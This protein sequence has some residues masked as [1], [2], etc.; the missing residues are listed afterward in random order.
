MISID[1]LEE[2]IQEILEGRLPANT[3]VG[4]ELQENPPFDNWVSYKLKNLQ[5]VGSSAWEY[6]DSDPDSDAFK[7]QSCWIADLEIVT[8]GNK[9]ADWALSLSHQFNKE[10]FRDLFEAIGLVFLSKSDIKYAPRLVSTGWEQ[11]NLF[12]VKFNMIVE[13]IDDV[14]YIEIV[15][16][17]TTILN[18]DDSVLYESTT[19]IDI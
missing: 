16:Y 13:D 1:A 14:P 5:Q 3:P 19:E 15:E 9:S 10:I 11:R 7:T 4:I 17:D 18:I 12:T 6:E 8:I 2:Q